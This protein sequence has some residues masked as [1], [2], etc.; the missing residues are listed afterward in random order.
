[1]LTT[2]SR[3]SS[4]IKRYV[5]YILTFS[6]IL[7][8]FYISLWN[9]VPHSG[10]SA[11]VSLVRLATVTILS[12]L[13]TTSV[14]N[15]ILLRVERDA[16]R[17]SGLSVAEETRNSNTHTHMHPFNGPFSGTTQVGQYQ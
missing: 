2:G 17:Q 1:L 15:I 16:A 7:I 13:A 6:F 4:G 11:T 14:Y 9:S 10:L 12:H 8:L 5:V 3:L